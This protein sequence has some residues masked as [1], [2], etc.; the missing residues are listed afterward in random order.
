MRST[1]RVLVQFHDAECLRS[2]PKTTVAS[3]LS[4]CLKLP[5][6]LFFIADEYLRTTAPKESFHCS[7]VSGPEWQVPPPNTAEVRLQKKPLFPTPDRHFVGH[8]YAC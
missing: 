8:R 1:A 6:C 7:S 2:F 3:G 5:S 4:A